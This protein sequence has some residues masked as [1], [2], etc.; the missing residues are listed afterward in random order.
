[1]ATTTAKVQEIRASAVAGGCGA[2]MGADFACSMSDGRDMDACQLH[3]RPAAEICAQLSGCVN[4]VIANNGWS[5]LKAEI[6]FSVAEPTRAMCTGL[7]HRAVER[8][9][10]RMACDSHMSSRWRKLGCAE[11]ATASSATLRAVAPRPSSLRSLLP[12]VSDH[13]GFLCAPD[14]QL[15]TKQPVMLMDLTADHARSCIRP[16]PT[17]DKGACSVLRR[18]ALH[19][20]DSIKQCH[21]LHCER[22]SDYC[23]MM[24]GRYSPSLVKHSFGDVDLLVRKEFWNANRAGSHSAQLCTDRHFYAVSGGLGAGSLYHG[25]S[26]LVLNCSGTSCMSTNAQSS[27]LNVQAQRVEALLITSSQRFAARSTAGEPT[28]V[29]HDAGPLVL[30]QPTA[31]LEASDRRAYPWTPSDPYAEQAAYIAQY[32]GDV[33]LADVQQVYRR[34]FG[35]GTAFASRGRK[36]FFVEAGAVQGTVF[37]SNSLFFERFLGWRGLLVEA[38]PFSFA[39]LLVRRPASYRLESALCSAAGI[40][41]F[42]LPDNQRTADGCCGRANG[43]G[44]HS[45]RCTPIGAVLRQIG[46]DHVDFWSL[47]V[48]GAEVRRK[49]IKNCTRRPPI[50]MRALNQVD[51]LFSVCAA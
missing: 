10:N 49:N 20:C 41:R 9:R 7:V 31:S 51:A 18:D 50:C 39:K 22:M 35:P 26:A 19:T 43:K 47:D 25:P 3:E 1:M 34:F 23:Q 8:A 37:D 13:R 28:A 33:W 27:V 29:V 11:F 15:A 12:K 48:E 40:M 5:T 36:G 2:M 46:V 4:V 16:S 24:R 44:K 45:L 17:E 30:Y 21:I 42:N 32:R 38:N 6:N 14:V